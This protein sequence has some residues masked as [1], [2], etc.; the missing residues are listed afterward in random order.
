MVLAPLVF[1]AAVTPAPVAPAPAAPTS[2]VRPATRPPYAYGKGLTFTSKS[3]RFSFKLQGRM[4]LRYE[5]NQKGD[6]VHHLPQ[7][8]RARLLFSGN[9]GSEH[10]KY[11]VQL[12]FSG[13][14][15]KNDLPAGAS[16][17]RTNNPLRDAR[18]EFTRVRDFNLWIGQFKSPF[19]R[20]RMMSSAVLSMVDRSNV[21]AEFNLDRNIG[22][23][24]FS[25]DLGGLGG[26][27]AY[28]TGVFTGAGRNTFDAVD[29]GLLYVGR[30]E[31]LP[32]GKF[33]DYAEND[34][35]RARKPGMSLG[36]AYA[37]QYRADAMRG[38][39]GDRPADGG[40]TDFH[41]VTAD[42]LFKW[43]GVT[44]AS[45]FHMRRGV[46]RINGGALD[47]AGAPLAT[48]AARQGVGWYGQL[49]WLVPRLPFEMVGRYGMI[50]NT[51]GASSSLP[52]GD[53]AGGSLNWYFKGNDLK[54]QVDYFKL[55]DP[56]MGPA[57]GTDRV[58]VQL[59]M[60]F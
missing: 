32:F 15:V 49:G 25:K 54:L 34:L 56:A 36:G 7:V 48:V 40:T 57:Q 31:V 28:Y 39:V 51:Y 11:Y 42:L 4:S 1:A 16:D 53:E 58:R 37:F 6:E 9:L 18:L 60:N 43:R 23:Q 46:R 41:H 44:V 17:L 22:V 5:F 21:N 20:Q 8:R 38:V 12:G 24:A 50:R 13:R 27:L 29:P 52:N 19:S 26:R 2:E 59:H 30:V 10:V 35:E 3:G 14:D 33:D 47:D 55:W 45:A